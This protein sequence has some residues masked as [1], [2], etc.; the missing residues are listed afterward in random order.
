[1]HPGK[2]TYVTPPSWNDARNNKLLMISSS[3]GLNIACFDFHRKILPYKEILQVY[4][5]E[6]KTEHRVSRM[7]LWPVTLH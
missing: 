5:L 3:L 1:M 7:R 6:N 4:R 2:N